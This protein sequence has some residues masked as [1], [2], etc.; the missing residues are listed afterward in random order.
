MIT[1]A[2]ISKSAHPLSNTLGLPFAEEWDN[3]T[4]LHVSPPQS[5][6][7]K[8][9]LVDLIQEDFPRTPSPVFP[10]RMRARATDAKGKHTLKAADEEAIRLSDS[11]SEDAA[12]LPRSPSPAG[13]LNMSP[14]VRVSARNDSDHESFVADFHHM[15]IRSANV[16]NRTY[17]DYAHADISTAPPLSAMSHYSDSRQRFNPAQRSST[18]GIPFLSSASFFLSGCG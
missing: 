6:M 2:Q 11:E 5:P 14:S 7:K 9:N 4:D 10:D 18:Y 8:K 3:K 1:L 13:K 17:R 15:N 16:D 12:S